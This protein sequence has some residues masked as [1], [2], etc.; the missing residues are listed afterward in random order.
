VDARRNSSGFDCAH[1]YI[2][3]ARATALMRY[4]EGAQQACITCALEPDAAHQAAAGAKHQEITHVSQ[5]KIDLRQLA[6]AQ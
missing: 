3:K 4:C 2:A 5:I 6:S 1:E